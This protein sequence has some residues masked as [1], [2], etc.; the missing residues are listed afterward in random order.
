ML[1]NLDLWFRVRVTSCP[2]V[3]SD[4]DVSDVCSADDLN[5]ISLMLKLSLNGD[6]RLHTHA[7]ISPLAAGAIQ[8]P[9][10]LS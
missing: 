4:C 3:A 10:M 5:S 7:V 2:S 8:S 1:V 6:D 9:N